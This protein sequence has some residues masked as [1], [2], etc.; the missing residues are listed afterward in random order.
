[1]TLPE[2]YISF[3]VAGGPW[4]PT[5]DM[6]SLSISAGRQN[7][8]DTYGA[9]TAELVMRR[10]S[11]NTADLDNLVPGVLVIIQ[12]VQQLGAGCQFRITDVINDYGLVSTMDTVT[13][14]MEGALALANRSWLNNYNLGADT[15]QNQI[16]DISTE[17]GITISPVSNNDPQMDGT[18]V[19]SVADWLQQFV[20]TVN[21]RLD[22][23][24]DI[25]VY[26]RFEYTGFIDVDTSDE[27]V[28]SDG[29]VSL[30]AG[31]KRLYYE[32]IVFTSLGENYYTQVIV[33]PENHAAQVATSATAVAPYRVLQLDTFNASTGQAQDYAD[34]LLSTYGDPTHKRVA[35]ITVDGASTNANYIFANLGAWAINSTVQIIFRGITYNAVIEG[36]TVTMTPGESLYTF[37]FSGA[38]L[39][40]Y[41]ILDDPD[42][43][44][45]DENR[46]GY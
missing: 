27:L 10:V 3:D 9:T 43:G 13:I 6:L 37:Y 21:G 23:S 39:N 8:L 38:D 22:D 24:N 45:L 12:D 30:S 42:R 11:A 33:D 18:T 17:S 40:N 4:E 15:F 36:W 26:D 46:L 20:T 16:Y 28:F 32:Q 14:T 29:T 35:S 41:L 34:F 5:T 7:A 19:T 31:Q 1:M 2:F 25:T 44:V